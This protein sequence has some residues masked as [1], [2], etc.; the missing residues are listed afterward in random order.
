MSTKSYRQLAGWFFIL[1]AVLVNIPYTLLILNFDYPDILRAPVDQILTEFQKGGDSL[2][3]IWLAFAWVGLPMLLGAIMLKRIL[4]NENSFFLETATTFGVMGFIVQVIGLLRWV[5]VVPILARLF[6]DP[7]TDSATRAAV[8][9]VFVAIHQYGGVVLG[10]HIG[11]LFTIVWMSMISA[12]LYKSP[13]FAKWVSWLGWIA[14]AVYLL[15][16]TELFVTIIPDFPVVDWAGLV[17]SLL[18]LL[19]MIVLGAYLIRNRTNQVGSQT[20]DLS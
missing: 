9:T 11:Q 20:R 19:W 12:I 16:Q 10:E 13:L 14:S 3:Y 1:G 7:R 17:G 2:I 18:W 15:A 8:A 5:F 4:E 6:T